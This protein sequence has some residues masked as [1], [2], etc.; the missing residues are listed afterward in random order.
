LP[1]QKSA[2][3][4]ETKSFSQ[5]RHTIR[6]P[7]VSREQNEEWFEMLR[8]DQWQR[9][10]I[11]DYP[12]IFSIPGVYEELVYRTLKCTSP[13]R[14][15][16]M[17]QFVLQDWQDMSDL[18]V[19]D[20]GAGNGIVAEVLADA[21]VEHIV[22]V[23]LLEEAA[24]AARRDRSGVYEDYI[25]ADL[26]KLNDDERKR[27]RDAECNCMAT[28]AALGFGDIPPRAFAV[29][30][31]QVSNPGW[32]A[33]AIKDDFLTSDDPSGFSQLI[34]RM[35]SEDIVEVQAQFR[36]CHRLSLAGEKLFYTGL[37]ARKL[38]DIPEAMLDEIE[39][40]QTPT[41]SAEA[42]LITDTLERSTS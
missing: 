5:P 17:L 24:Q 27:L 13:T 26:C 21:G 28:V 3:I 12:E 9:L 32:I 31:N 11:H 42:E 30:V 6:F 19:L 14:I 2:F 10:R 37:I 29:A 40:A 25:V 4:H 38:K 7:S 15:A 39:L 23:D 8:K 1:A 41:S 18:R 16:H 36:Y 20:L 22:G 35:M 33:M 34:R